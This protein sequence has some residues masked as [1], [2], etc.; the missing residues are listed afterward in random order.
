MQ[1]AV[2]GASG[3]VGSATASQLHDDGHVVVP[4]TAPRVTSGARTLSLLLGHAS[5]DHVTQ[6]EELTSQISGADAV[7]NCAGL[8][9]P[10]STADDAL[11]GANALLPLLLL[12]ACVA[13]G[14]NRLVHVSTAAVLGHGVLRDGWQSD[15]RTPYAHSKALGEQAL[16]SAA[17][18]AVSVRVLRPTSVHGRD[19]RTTATLVRLAGSPW[20]SVAGDGERPSPQVLVGDVAA[21][22]CL[23][24]TSDDPP[25]HPVVQPWDGVTV[26]SV[27]EDLGGGR[28]PRS[29]PAPL[30]HLAV[31][32]GAA[33]PHP[34]VRGQ[35]RR[36]QMLW[37]GQAHEE[38]WL[39][40]RGLGPSLDRRA[41][42][43]LGHALRVEGASGLTPRR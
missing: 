25:E 26:R 43:E 19:R 13:S 4:V 6:V 36:V 39:A 7:V 31:S 40:H 33:V 8:A 32:V 23:L 38:G 5:A 18:G 27:L 21:A 35:A 28:R 15:A 3:F 24:L 2:L 34:W 12:H 10:T 11:Y 1:V 29:I 30:A 20:S 16:R 22:I 9:A 37:F 14:V 17:P 41:W 42:R